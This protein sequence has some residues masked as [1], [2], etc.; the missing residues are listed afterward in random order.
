[1]ALRDGKHLRRSLLAL[2]AAT[3]A[4]LACATAADANFVAAA[5]DA[6]G[7]STDPSPGR[8]LTG[9]ALSYDRRSGTLNGAVRF[10]G[11]PTA[12]APAL[13]TL[14]AGRRTEAG[15][16]GHPAAGFGGDSTEYGARWLRL[17]DPAGNGPRGDAVKLG[18]N[19]SLQRFEATDEQLAGQ[20]V[21]CAIAML[22]QPGNAAN[23]YDTAGP[24]DLVGQPALGLK[25]R[26]VPRKISR[27]RA[28]TIR[29]TLSNPGDAPTGPV[30]LRLSR[31]RGLTVDVK[32][33]LKPIPAGGR[34]TVKAKVTLGRRARTTTDLKVTATADK[35]RVR[36]EATLVLR[37]P[38]GGGGGGGSGGGVCTRYVGYP[39]G[40]S[41]LIL[42][43]C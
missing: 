11:D 21:D 7:D 37:T 43:P 28:R 15:C 29:L 9:I 10:A 4:A 12:E 40:S 22:S 32:R 33:T 18:T 41:A 26:G 3:A 38:G 25:I 5:D 35:L 14:F 34:R 16:N 31:P 6:A 23:I 20:P 36:A 17:D 1:M 19:T 13:V 39:D 42:V 30:R 27:D 2:L 24:L 8:D